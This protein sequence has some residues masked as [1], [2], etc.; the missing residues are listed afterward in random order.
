MDRVPSRILWAL[1]LAIFLALPDLLGA[2]KSAPANVP[3]ATNL[4]DRQLANS[5]EVASSLYQV[6]A[7]LVNL[8]LSPLAMN[9]HPVEDDCAIPHESHSLLRRQPEE[10]VVPGPSLRRAPALRDVGGD[11]KQDHLVHGIAC[12]ILRNSVDER[13]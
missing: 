2:V 1:V 9:V 10:V 3:M 4:V 11:A 7:E 12:R 8:G 6:P 13:E 5:Y